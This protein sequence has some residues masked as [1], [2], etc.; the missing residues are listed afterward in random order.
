MRKQTNRYRVSGSR[1]GRKRGT[2]RLFV[3]G[4]FAASA[5]VTGPGVTTA[6]AAQRP[7]EGNTLVSNAAGAAQAA[8]TVR[9]DIPAGPL[10]DAIRRFED[11][12][13]IKVNV[14]RGGIGQLQSPGVSGVM[15]AQ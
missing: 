7:G 15:T 2:S 9:F 6:Q 1:R 12:T 8:A 5:V 4:A 3:L 13:H 11:L 10:G 14:T